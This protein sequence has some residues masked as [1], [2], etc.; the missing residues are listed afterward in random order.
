[1]LNNSLLI[2]YLKMI[3]EKGFE[4]TNKLLI[5]IE[6]LMEQYNIDLP[7][8]DTSRYNQILIDKKE[9]KQLKKISQK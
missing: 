7:I 8:V 2:P 3:R 4:Y 1:M 5:D 6:L 9:K